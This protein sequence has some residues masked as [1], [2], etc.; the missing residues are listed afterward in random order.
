MRAT[1]LVHGGALASVAIAAVLVLGSQGR[2][3]RAQLAPV[4]LYPPQIGADGITLTWSASQAEAYYVIYRSDPEHAG[5][6]AITTV[7]ATTWLD[8]D[9]YAPGQYCYSVSVSVGDTHAAGSNT[10]CVQILTAKPGG[11]VG[12]VV[13]LFLP[14]T[15]SPTPQPA[16]TQATP[17]PTPTA[18]PTPSATPAPALPPAIAVDPASLPAGCSVA[19]VQAPAGTAISDVLAHG[20][21]P[22]AVLAV[23]AVDPAGGRLQSLYFEE[24]SAPAD[25]PPRTLS[26][27]QLVWI[28]ALVPVSFH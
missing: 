20:S 26:D 17:A 19:R 5:T 23:W 3:A 16:P 12:S 15:P 11:V 10:W 13:G 28:C 1:R 24:P 7:S 18:S 25:L 22:T 27:Q 14:P 8:E 9:V 4:V 6:I 2:A 21:A